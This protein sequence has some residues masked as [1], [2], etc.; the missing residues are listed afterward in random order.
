MCSIIY[1]ANIFIFSSHNNMSHD[2][3]NVKVSCFP[4]Q[5]LF[6]RNERPMLSSNNTEEE[7]SA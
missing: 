5:Y 6:K 3:L 7:N 1:H 2:H 4:H